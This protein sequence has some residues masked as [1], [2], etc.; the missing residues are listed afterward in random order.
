[1]FLFIIQYI[2]ITLR[3][4]ATAFVWWI[5]LIEMCMYFI[6]AVCIMIGAYRTDEEF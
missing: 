4:I 6:S 3:G 2:K 1:M 5:T